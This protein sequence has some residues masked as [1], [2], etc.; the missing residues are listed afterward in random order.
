MLLTIGEQ[1]V[2]SLDGSGILEVDIA[3][4][5]LDEAAEAVQGEG[6]QFNVDHDVALT[7]D[8]G[9]RILLPANCYRVWTRPGTRP[10]IVQRGARLYN[11]TDHCFTFKAPMAV[12]IMY[13]LEFDELPPAARR[14]IACRARRLF[15]ERIN[16]SQVTE[17]FALREE[18]LSRAQLEAAE[19]ASANCNILSDNLPGRA[20][21][22]RDRW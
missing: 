1:K 19:A 5:T 20:A 11:R 9:G 12:S 22:G 21:I 4:T 3:K 10:E 6:W 16:G 17:E 8:E 18:A 2:N 13:R 14:H 7:P 15:Q